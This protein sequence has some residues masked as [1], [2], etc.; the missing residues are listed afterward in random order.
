M[1]G[2]AVPNLLASAARAIDPTIRQ[3]D[4]IRQTLMGRIPFL[5]EEVAPRLAGTGEPVL[6]GETGISRF[7]SPFRYSEEAG[8]EANLERLFLEAGYNPSSPPRS[9]SVP[10]G[11]GRKIEL[12]D[13]ERRLYAAYSTRATAFARELAKNADWDRLDIYAKEEF[14]KRIYRFAHDAARRELYRSIFVRMKR[15]EAKVL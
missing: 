9:I 15:G 1:I 6:R 3:S 14:L 13:Q 4:T 5:S 12:P 7:M 10:G 8:P 11:M 2:A